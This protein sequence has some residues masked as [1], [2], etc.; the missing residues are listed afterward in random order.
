MSSSAIPPAG[1]LPSASPV[2]FPT[3]I[4][5]STADESA[6]ALRLDEHQ[7]LGKTYAIV[8][9]HGLHDAYA[10]FLPPLLPSF[11][12]NLG[13]NK[14]E[15]GLLTVFMQSPS[16]LQ[17]VIG[18]LADRMGLR[19]LIICAPAIT[20]ISMSLL[21]VAP[22]YA[23]LAIC[24]VISGIAAAGLHAVGTAAVGH[25]A[26]DRLG[27]S[28]GYWMMSGEFGYSIGAV[29]LVTAVKYLGLG[30]ITWLMIP[31]ICASI[32]LYVKLHNIELGRVAPA[33]RM[34]WRQTLVVMRPVIVPVVLVMTCRSF[35]DAA[36]NSYMP[37]FLREQG[38]S[39]WLAGISL[40]IIGFSGV[41]GAMI[42]GSLSDRIGRKAILVVTIGTAPLLMFVFL[43]VQGALRYPLLMAMGFTGM[44]ASPVLLALIQESSPENRALG[45]GVYMAT[46]M[47]VRSFVVVLVGFLSD[48][49]GMS[50][51]FAISAAVTLVAIPLISLL[52]GKKDPGVAAP[53][54]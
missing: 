27:R 46:G 40:T 33:Y 19:Y 52:P 41:V 17:P 35:M 39:L 53:G 29:V 8:S 26:G 54:H 28:M 15:A 14:T 50:T 51:A 4:G 6:E 20:A 16:L 42:A 32:F 3:E 22:S 11:I 1:Q 21:G 45:S 5:M 18:Y 44:A 31:G 37:T 25:L 10:S 36:L 9:G 48:Q 2:A 49:L 38:S 47:A 43:A 30:G 24:L 34:P 7:R 12:E 13:I 23:V